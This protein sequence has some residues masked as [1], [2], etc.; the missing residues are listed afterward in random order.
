MLRALA[1]SFLLK[2]QL[3]SVKSDDDSTLDKTFSRAVPY[4]SGS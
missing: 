1:R 3:S 2:E 4:F